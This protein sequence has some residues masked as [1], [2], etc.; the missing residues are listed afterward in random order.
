MTYLETICL[1][2]ISLIL[3][4]HIIYPGAMVV[5]SFLPFGKKRDK[6]VITKGPLSVHIVIPACNEEKHIYQKLESIAIAQPIEGRLVVTVLDDGSQDNTAIEVKRAKRD[7][8]GCTIHFIEGKR[9][10]GKVTRINQHLPKIKETVIILTDCS[11]ILK[12]DALVIV[13][14]HFKNKKIGVV[15]GGYTLSKAAPFAQKLYWKIQTLVKLGENRLG[16]L[17][18]AHGA[19]YAIRTSLY[20]PLPADTINDDFI[21]PMQIA[22]QGARVIYDPSVQTI[23]AQVDTLQQDFSRRH[24][25]GAGN[26]QQVLILWPLIV[27][28]LFSSISLCAIFGK[29]IRLLIGPSLITLAIIL[30]MV[31]LMSDFSSVFIG[32]FVGAII[33]ALAAVRSSNSNISALTQ[34]FGFFLWGH[35]H[36]TVGAVKYLS[37]RDKGWTKSRQIVPKQPLTYRLKRAVDLTFGSMALIFLAPLFPIIALAI[38]ID[39]RGPILFRQRRIGCAFPTHTDIFEMLKF[40]SMGT[41][42]EQDGKPVWAIEQDPRV[43][44]V[45]KFLRKTRLDELPQLLNVIRGD[46]SLIGP[47]PERPGF[48]Q[49]LENAIPFFAERTFWIRPG[50]TGLAQVTQGYTETVEEARTKALFDHAYALKTHHLA[51]WLRTDSKIVLDTFLVMALGRGR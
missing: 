12:K 34:T 39:S 10:L 4:H 33:A 31:A 25:I 16:A 40:R 7:F 30:P 47:R 28:K 19:F 14:N 38:K 35:W 49:D 41:D 13:K 29:F 6:P 3:F 46:M 36:S 27:S 22:L 15:S 17:I 32:L 18:G 24:R 8:T 11:A 5:L 51:D 1:G 50:I 23:E 26:L 43:T 44:R 37:G 2:L 20:Q 42:A 9:N 21:I 48:Y 45:G